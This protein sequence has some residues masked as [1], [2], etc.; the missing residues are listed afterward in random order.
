[1]LT[2]A[3]KKYLFAIYRLG[4]KGGMIS[5]SDISRLVGVT[6]ASTVKMTQRLTDE[7]YILKEP[8]GKIVLTDEGAKAASSL[9]TSSLILCDFL[10]NKVGIDENNADSDAVKIVTQVS[11]DTVDKLVKYALGDTAHA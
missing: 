5:S 9:F 10:R 4:N 11:E 3:Q 1:M 2:Y 8:Y 6:K 7:G